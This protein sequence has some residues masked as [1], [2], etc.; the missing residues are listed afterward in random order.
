MDL[1]GQLIDKS[2]ILLDHSSGGGTRYRMLETVH[3]AILLQDRLVESGRGE[4]RC[5]NATWPTSL[6]LLYRP[7]PICAPGNARRWLD[8]LDQ[9]LDNLRLALEWS[10]SG[11]INKGLRLAAALKWFWH[12]RNSRSEGVEWL[13]RLFEAQETR[14]GSQ[15]VNS[16][17]KLAR[18]KALIA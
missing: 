5:A 17:A 1:F 9:E 10:L 7:S 18:G 4:K 11:S 2:L 16:A 12:M 6:I 3:P 15:P 8:R 14:P 13:D